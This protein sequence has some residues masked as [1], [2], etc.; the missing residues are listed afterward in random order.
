MHPNLLLGKVIDAQNNYVQVVTPFGC[1]K[2]LIAPTRLFPCTATNVKLDY[3]KE[4]PLLVHVN[5]LLML[6]KLTFNIVTELSAI[7]TMYSL[8]FS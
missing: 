6:N 1:I 3:E 5:W 4:F 7:Y 8:L 2:G